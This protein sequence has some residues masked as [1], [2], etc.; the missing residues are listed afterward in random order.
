MR[1]RL[2]IAPI[3]ALA[4]IAC[5]SEIDAPPPAP[6]DLSGRAIVVLPD[7]QYYACAYGEIFERQTRW[8][9]EQQ[10]AR[11]I[12]LVLHTGDIVD[13]DVDDQWRVAADSFELLAGSVPFMVTTGNH[14]LSADRASLFPSY[15]EPG[16]LSMWDLEAESFEPGRSDN[17][18]AV[19][20]LADRDWLVLGLEFGPRDRVVA[21]AGEVLREHAELP[22]ILFTHAYLYSDGMR[23]DRALD[24]RQPYHP[25]SYGQTPEQGINDGEDLWKKLVVPNENVRLVLS[26]HVIPDGVARSSVRR[27]SGQLVHQVLANYQ[28]CGSCPC[29]EFEGGGGYLRVLEFGAGAIDVKTYSPH[30]DR[31]MSDEENEFV[32]EL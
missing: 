2:S 16:E 27:A 12:G 5:D 25:D 23:Y 14:D 30:Y 15:F 29:E 28:H 3:L 18:Y 4:L 9:A 8:V 1:A 17:S 19:V 26:G 24:P 7:T 20:R 31:W 32:L 22:A 10:K 6:P 21:W 13:R 11:G